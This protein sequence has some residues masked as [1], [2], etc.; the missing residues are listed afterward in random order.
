MQAKMWNKR[1]WIEISD[2][3]FLRWEYEKLLRD[4]GFKIISLQE[5]QFQ[6]YGYTALFLLAESHFAI[7]TFPECGKAYCE[8][9]SCVRKYF[10]RFIKLA[11]ERNLEGYNEIQK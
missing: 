4:S 3:R 5:H 7:H 1:F 11:K 2:E 9:S 8:L 10:N 6:P